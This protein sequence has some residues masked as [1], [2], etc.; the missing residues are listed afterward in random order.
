MFIK[1]NTLFALLTICIISIGFIILTGCNNDKKSIFREDES[2]VTIENDMISVS[3]SKKDGC[4]VSIYDKIKNIEFIDYRENTT[5]F[6]IDWKSIIDGSFE[7]FS[8]QQ[9]Y[10]RR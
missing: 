9:Y 6:R 1:K 4:I 2:L 7:T 8:Y 5:P 10:E 3:F